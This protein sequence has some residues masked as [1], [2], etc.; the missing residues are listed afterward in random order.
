[1]T[2]KASSGYSTEESKCC[3]V[4]NCLGYCAEQNNYDITRPSLRVI[5]PRTLSEFEASAK[6][7]GCRYCDYTFQSFLLLGSES[8]NPKVELLCYADSPTE[9]HSA[10]NED[11]CDVVEIYPCPG[12]SLHPPLFSSLRLMVAARQ[13]RNRRFPRSR[14]MFQ[15]ITYRKQLYSSSRRIT[16][17]AAPFIANVP[18]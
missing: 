5:S 12:T 4:C 7:R 17:V 14:T 16:S 10:T 6:E 2:E 3:P 9:L 15:G 18:R 1:M 13:I 11:G 8:N